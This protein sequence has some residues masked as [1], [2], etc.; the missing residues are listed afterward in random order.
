[1]VSVADFQ[2]VQAELRAAREQITA[3]ATAH[4]DLKKQAQEAIAASE[5]RSGQLARQLTQQALTAQSPNERF[6]LIDFKINKPDP[7]HGERDESWRAW[8]RQFK[9]YCNA[10]KEGMRTAL[11]WAESFEG[12]VINEA[13]V[14][15]LNWAAGRMSNIKLYDF[16]YL[17]CKSDARVLLER[18]E[19]MGFE[20]WRQLARR[21]SPS[22]GRLE[23]ELMN[24]LM[25]PQRAAKL[26]DIPSAIL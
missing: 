3:I 23:L 12:D 10:R 11:D 1:M 17:L 14:D 15:T 7:F 20:A 19:G 25:N 5:A 22:G 21:Y 18:Y 2:Q 24:K 4:E 6:D 16:L 8:S 9:T 26:T 13:A